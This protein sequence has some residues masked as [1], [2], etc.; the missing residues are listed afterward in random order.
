M[1]P[2][3]PIERNLNGTRASDFQ[4]GSLL[5][6]PRTLFEDIQTAINDNTFDESMACEILPD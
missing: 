5:E 2:V 1:F 3:S 4:A 6:V